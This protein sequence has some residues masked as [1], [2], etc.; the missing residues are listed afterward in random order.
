MCRRRLPIQFE[1]HKD[2]NPLWTAHV[3]LEVDKGLGSFVEIEVMAHE[4]GGDAEKQIECIKGE[5]GIEG[6]HIPQSYLELLRP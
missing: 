5:L 3:A 4:L 1:K 6:D 2:A